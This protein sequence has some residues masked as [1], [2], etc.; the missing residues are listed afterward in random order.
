VDLVVRNTEIAKTLNNGQA[1]EIADTPNNGHEPEIAETLN[2]RHNKEDLLLEGAMHEEA[3]QQAAEANT[4]YG[5]TV[6][7]AR[8]TVVNELSPLLQLDKPDPEKSLKDYIPEHYHEYLD[9]FIEKEAIPLLLHWPWD[10]VV[11]LT[12]DAPPSI[13]CR[14]YPLSCGEEEFQ[15]KYIKEQEDAGLIRKLKSQYSTPVFY[16][17][18]KNRSY[19]PIFNYRRVNTITVKDVFPLPCIDMIIEGM[20]SM[21]LFSKFDLCNGYWNIRNSEEMEDLMAF[22]MTRG[23]YAPRVMSFGPTNAPACMQRFMNHIFQ[24]L[25]DRY[26]GRFENY[27]DDC[28]VV[29]REGELDLHQQIT[30]EFFEILQEKHLFLWPQKCLVEAEEMDFL[31]MR[32]NCHGITIDPSKIKGLTDWPRELKN[33]KEIHKVLG[34]LVTST[35][36]SQTSHASPNPLRTC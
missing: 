4:S 23:L 35:P 21:V 12:P 34:V 17:K 22:K 33:I 3:S 2:N 32:L 27:M 7:E 1:M 29:T 25:R 15:A 13:S 6:M 11:T 26:P 8:K 10:H 18:K 28:S 36:L 14:V 30:K 31:G 16:I 24:P 19:R 9:I 20:R 5:E